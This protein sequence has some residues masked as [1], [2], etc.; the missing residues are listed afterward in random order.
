MAA[1]VGGGVEGRWRRAANQLWTGQDGLQGWS[2]AGA[3]L[4]F[5]LFP[6]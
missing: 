6:K 4:H 2:A 3:R 1:V 5:H